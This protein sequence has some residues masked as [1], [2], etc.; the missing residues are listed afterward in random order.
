MIAFAT[1]TP[2]LNTPGR[3][4]QRHGVPL[5]RVAYSLAARG[6]ISARSHGPSPFYSMT[7]VP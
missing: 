3:I 7:S 2:Q 4:A 5:H 6:D 1:P